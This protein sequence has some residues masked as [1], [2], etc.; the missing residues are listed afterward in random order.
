M[1][2]FL[3]FKICVLYPFLAAVLLCSIIRLPRSKRINE[4]NAHHTII[5]SAK[6]SFRR[7]H[8][9]AK[10]NSVKPYDVLSFFIN[11]KYI[12]W[13]GVFRLA[14]KGFYIIRHFN[15]LTSSQKCRS[16]K[17]NVADLGLASAATYGIL[18]L[19]S[20]VISPDIE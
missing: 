6:F 13:G 16:Y 12:Y 3:L 4:T 20:Y 17:A 1:I 9:G 8:N 15:T 2:L 11:I 10:R 7:H 19:L 5:F 18:A 14:K